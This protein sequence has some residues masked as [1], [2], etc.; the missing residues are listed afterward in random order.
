M[1]TYLH[2]YITHCIE[3]NSL[4]KMF[5]VINFKDIGYLFKGDRGIGENSVLSLPVHIADLVADIF[6]G[7][8]IIYHIFMSLCRENFLAPIFWLLGDLMY[9]SVCRT[10]SACSRLD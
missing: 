1:Y 4:A 2:L 10:P 8:H 9:A 5:T 3:E 7:L 6:P